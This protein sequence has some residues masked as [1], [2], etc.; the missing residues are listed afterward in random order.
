MTDIDISEN[1]DRRSYDENSIR[2]SNR[3]VVAVF[4]IALGSGP[5]SNWVSNKVDPPKSDLFTSEDASQMK[6]EMKQWVR[7][8][9]TDR[10][11]SIDARCNQLE[12]R[13]D[14]LEDLLFD[15]HL[16]P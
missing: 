7:S 13:A 15:S 5:A 3:L 10:C 14:R 11:G 9:F 2:I 4:A 6:K 16:D 12:R 1:K 8:Y